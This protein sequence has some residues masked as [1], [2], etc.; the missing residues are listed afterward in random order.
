MLHKKMLDIATKEIGVKEIDG[1]GENKRI[2]EYH[3]CTTLKA[4]SEEV[5]WCSAFVNWVCAQIPVP[6]TNNAMARSWLLWGK[7]VT[8]PM[9]GDIVVFSRGNDGVSGH[10]AFLAETPG[11][12]DLF[13]KV[14][15]G[16]Q[17]NSV[18]VQKYLRARVLGYR[19]Y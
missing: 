9:A 1:S 6:G 2:L 19:R 4:T 14:L 15:G 12:M 5:P 7:P 17:T 3:K 10:V 13:V 8:E 18:C 11:S 16:N